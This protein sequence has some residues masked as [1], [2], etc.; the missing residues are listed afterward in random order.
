MEE[1]RGKLNPSDFRIDTFRSSGSGGQHINK[2]DSAV[3]ITHLPTGII[4][5]CS[6][7]RSQ[8]RNKAVALRVLK[9]K[10]SSFRI[11][12]DSN[13][14]D[15][16]KISASFGYQIRNYILFPY[17]LIK[18][19]RNKINTDKVDNIFEGHIKIFTISFLIWKYL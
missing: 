10:M 11:Y 19:V 3:R 5:T 7:E 9:Q 16:N 13:K 6:S 1:D 17:K 2:T 12:E 18:D 14:N 8:L 15:I 4:A